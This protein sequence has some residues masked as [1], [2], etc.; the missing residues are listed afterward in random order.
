MP[1]KSSV[2]WY[3]NTN[4]VIIGNT[5]TGKSSLKRALCGEVFTGE[6]TSVEEGRPH[7]LDQRE[8]VYED[9]RREVRETLICT[10]ERPADYRLIHQLHLRE[11]AVVLIALDAR[12]DGTLETGVSECMRTLQTII[13]EHALALKFFLVITCKD[14]VGDERRFFTRKVE[15][16]HDELGCDG[17]FETSAKRG[18]GI[19]ELR[20]ALVEAIDWEKQPEACPMNLMQQ[21]Q[22][23][24]DERREEGYQFCTREELYSACELFWPVMSNQ[25]EDLSPQLAACLRCI[26]ARGDIHQFGSGGDILLCPG[27]IDRYIARWFDEAR[28]DAEG[29]GC[30]DEESARRGVFSLEGERLQERALEQ[31]VLGT[32]ID[33]L[34]CYGLVLRGHSTGI[35]HKTALVFPAQ[36]L[37]ANYQIS[38]PAQAYYIFHFHGDIARIYLL[39]AVYLARSTIFV[40]EAVG[41]HSVVYTVED[42]K[43]CRLLLETQNKGQGSLT[44]CFDDGVSEMT[45]KLFAA[46]VFV[47]LATCDRETKGRAFPC[48]SFCDNVVTADQEK[49]LREHGKYIF[50]CFVCGQ[51]MR[52]PDEAPDQRQRASAEKPRL[53]EAVKQRRRQNTYDVFLC[54]SDEQQ[55]KREVLRLYDELEKRGIAAWFE[56]KDLPPG[57]PG[58]R[59]MANQ[60]ERVKAA[61]VC[62]GIDGDTQWLKMQVE[63]LLSQLKRRDCRIILVLLE[64]A[65]RKKPMLPFLY[66]TRWVDFHEPDPDPLKD[67]IWGIEGERPS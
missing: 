7:R 37:Q 18:W 55:D 20:K 12:S 36:A 31:S 60:I 39:L 24:L 11:V 32:L 53:I 66:G 33:D 50:R 56:E 44:L 67:L 21:V 51:E 6:D 57:V 59:E 2:V 15:E 52:L 17:W 63:A 8:N 61:V 3:R 9:G 19:G 28:D 14:R 41:Q 65:P 26:E 43:R 45:R 49:R 35:A 48:C 10:M 25:R 27:L 40:A 47:H 30:I 22:H 5:N 23:Y 34:L 4:V 62:F 46:Y 1:G 16:L 29:F 58:L 64:H 13:R 38:D 54:C 42:G